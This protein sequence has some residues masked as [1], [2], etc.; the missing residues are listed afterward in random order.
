MILLGAFP[1]ASNIGVS[2]EFGFCITLHRIMPSFLL[3]EWC[4]L[5]SFFSWYLR[6][7]YG[8][9]CIVGFCLI[10]LFLMFLRRFLGWASLTLISSSI[11]CGALYCVVGIIHFCRGR[12][13]GFIRFV[14]GFSVKWGG[15]DLR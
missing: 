2:L 7:F 12:M 10:V 1:D 4:L 8:M 5:L 14:L 6:G 3:W 11:S 15:V 9:Y 13:G